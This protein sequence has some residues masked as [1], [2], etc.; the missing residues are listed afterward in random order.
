MV[1]SVTG[2]DF[3]K[4]RTDKMISSIFGLAGSEHFNVSLEQTIKKKLIL[5]P[6]N[7]FLIV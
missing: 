3:K 6:L 4:D 1:L 2:L 7:I 5:N